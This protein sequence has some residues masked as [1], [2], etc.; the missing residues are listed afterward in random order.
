MLSV[1]VPKLVSVADFTVL[2]VETVALPNLSGF[3]E[4]VTFVPVPV[5]LTT[6][7]LVGSLSVIVSVL[8]R[9][10]DAAGVKVTVIEQ[11]DPAAIPLPHAEV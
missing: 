11:K 6:W 5:R 10:P 1:A 8:V 9:V 2:V 4:R 3:G 7:G